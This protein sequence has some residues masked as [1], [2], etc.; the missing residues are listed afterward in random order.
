MAEGTVGMFAEDVRLSQ[1]SRGDP[2][3]IDQVFAGPG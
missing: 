2:E 3:L 1:V